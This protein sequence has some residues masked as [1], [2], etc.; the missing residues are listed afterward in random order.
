MKGKV[1]LVKGDL[2]FGVYL[3]YHLLL[4]K[5]KDTR[6]EFLEFTSIVDAKK[7]IQ[8]IYGEKLNELQ[9]QEISVN[10]MYYFCE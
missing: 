4:K 7:K 5:I 9:H 10:K 1:F 6:L 3:S 8:E 2:C